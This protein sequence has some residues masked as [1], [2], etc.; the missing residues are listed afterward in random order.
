VSRPRSLVSSKIPSWHSVDRT[1]ALRSAVLRQLIQCCFGARTSWLLLGLRSRMKF[2]SFCPGS[3]IRL[4]VICPWQ[5]ILQLVHEVGTSMP[6]PMHTRWV[7]WL[8]HVSRTEAPARVGLAPGATMQR[9]A[10]CSA[11]ELRSNKQTISSR[12]KRRQ[13]GFRCSTGCGSAGGLR[14]GGRK[15]RCSSLVS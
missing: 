5:Q 2:E 3:G 14:C 10:R 6:V 15:R 12:T 1:P 13:S 7:Q 11:R 9:A 4:C 8:L